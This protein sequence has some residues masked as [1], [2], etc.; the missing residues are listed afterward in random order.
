MDTTTQNIEGATVILDAASFAKWWSAQE[1]AAPKPD[2]AMLEAAR[3]AYENTF[4]KIAAT[5]GFREWANA[6]VKGWKSR[7]AD[8]SICAV[9]D[10]LAQ[11]RQR[12]DDAYLERNRCVALVAR[13]ALSMGLGVGVA[14]TAIEGWSEDWHGCVYI[15]LPTGQ[16][17]WHFHDSQAGLFAGLPAYE[18]SWD[19]HSTPEKYERVAAAFAVPGADDTPV[20]M[21]AAI[22]A[23]EVA[24][25]VVVN[26]EPINR[27]EGNTEQADLEAQSA[28][29]IEQAL[30]VLRTDAVED[31]QSMRALL[32]GAGSAL[33]KLAV[34]RQ[35]KA[36]RAAAAA[37]VEDGLTPEEYKAIA[38]T[39]YKQLGGSR[40]KVMTGAKDFTV[41]TLENAKAPNGGLRFS[42]PTGFSQIDG[43]STGINRV[44]IRLNASD[45]YDIE[46]GGARGKSYTVRKTAED[47]YA[48]NLREVFTRYTGLDT[49]MGTGGPNPYA[50][51]RT[52]V[53]AASDAMD[54]LR[55]A[56]NDL[57][58]HSDMEMARP[59]ATDRIESAVETVRRM[60]AGW[61]EDFA[62]PR[63][64]IEQAE[65][66]IDRAKAMRAEGGIVEISQG[67]VKSFY[68]QGS[69]L[70]E[71]QK[72]A[73][74]AKPSRV[75]RSGQFDVPRFNK[76]EVEAMVKAFE[77][78]NAKRPEVLERID[79]DDGMYVNI[80]A[81]TRKEG[82]F[83][84]VL[85]DGDSEQTAGAFIS[86]PTMEA[87]REKAR[88]LLNIKPEEAAPAV[89]FR[90][91]LLNRPAGFET[92]PQGLAYTVEPRPAAGQ[93]HHDMARHGI[94]MAER[95][96][97]AQEVKAFELAPLID[98]PEEHAALAEKV[99]Q[100]MAEHALAYLEQ[101]KEEPS[102]FRSAVMQTVEASAS[103]IAYSIGNPDLL[104]QSVA[105]RLAAMIPAE[106]PAPQPAPNDPIA[107]GSR[108]ADVALLEQV[109]AGRHPQ[110]L[111]P[112]LAEAIEAALMRYPDDKAIQEL[113]DRAVVAYSNGLMAATQ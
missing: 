99:A 7:P 106:P 59:G 44:F 66:L 1:A 60:E 113:G 107:A 9:S 96:L 95:E 74:L 24:R 110:M 81:S 41:L 23:L 64:T 19:G 86:M 75:L 31:L 3:Q 109:A 88:E 14:R 12:K 101:A 33:E 89:R 58:G 29:E 49:S 82:G 62:S 22:A 98:G 91:A 87:A 18:G 10:E 104:V 27:A 11:M 15:E 72:A 68:F 32:S 70:T 38:E 103:G 6:F 61:P 100:A 93:P 20:S 8:P 50:T 46:F 67:D 16:C 48:D 43:K 53:Q 85:R 21:D 30:E 108:E 37:E 90:Y 112:E 63:A 42:L 55:A 80:V 52:G 28:V 57:Q 45:T 47:I 35:I 39:I 92:L 56:I 84:V 76:A 51:K 94:L 54:A 105:D 69:T 25:D 36:A 79:G 65:G 102:Y 77:A 13:M 78:E 2:P 34:A 26:N 5:V 111:E 83:N 71:E 97:T 17:S 40:F 4:H 73:I